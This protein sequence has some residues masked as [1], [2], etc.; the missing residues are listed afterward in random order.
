MPTALSVNLVLAGARDIVHALK[1][2]LP[3]SPLAPLTDSEAA[4]LTTITKVLLNRDP[5]SPVAPL[6]RVPAAPI[7]PAS[8]PTSTI[9][10]LAAPAPAPMPLPAPA[11]VVVPPP[12][13]V[14]APAPVAAPAP[15]IDRA[16]VPASVTARGPFA[17]ELLQTPRC[18]SSEGAN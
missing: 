13:P 9:N 3:G 16:P 7:P 2:P 10:P 12:P 1:H 4:E 14:V 8:L 5:N 11:P 17:F 18:I 15:T 6:L